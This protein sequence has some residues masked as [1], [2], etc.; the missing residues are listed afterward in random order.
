MK[1][2]VS[3][4]Q[5]PKRIGDF[6][7]APLLRSGLDWALVNIKDF[8]YVSFNS[9]TKSNTEGSSSNVNDVLANTFVYADKR[10]HTRNI[11]PE[12]KDTRVLIGAG[13][14]STVLEGSLSALPS[15]QKSRGSNKFQELWTVTCAESTFCK[16]CQLLFV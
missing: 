13:Q 7:A 3:Q 12:P 2:D 15:F 9:A 5:H 6:F 10:I 16:F 14:S 11:A 8:E 4:G 1:S